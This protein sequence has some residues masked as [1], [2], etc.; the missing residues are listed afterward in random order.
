MNK[1]R[2]IIGLDPGLRNTGWGVIDVEGHLIR[3]VANGTVRSTSDWALSDRLLQL[4]DGLWQVMETYQPVD[5]AVEETF[6]NKNPTSTLKLGLARGTVIVTAAKF[7]LAVTEY[8]PNKV[9]KVVTGVGHASKEQIQM[10]IGVLL[11]QCKLQS[12]D[13]ADAL[14]VAICHSRYYETTKLAKKLE[15]QI[16]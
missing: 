2:R 12:P 14:A 5:S 1:V 9:K 3:H 6:V 11:P 7:G 13:A 4:Y 8:K 15:E 10:M 16:A